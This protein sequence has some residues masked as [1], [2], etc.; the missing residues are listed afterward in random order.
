M[1]PDTGGVDHCSVDDVVGHVEQPADERHVGRLHEI[2]EGL[3]LARQPTHHEAAFGARGHDDRVL[4]DLGLQQP[5]HLCPVVLTPIG[6]ADPTAGHHA[7]TQVYAL[8]VRCIHE[9]LVER[10][11]VG[12]VGDARG[13]ELYAER[14]PPRPVCVRPLR[15]EDQLEE[16]AQDAVLV[17]RADGIEVV[18]DGGHDRVL[19]AATAHRVEPLL[20]QPHQP[21]CDVGMLHERVVHVLDGERR[22]H[23]PPVRAVGPQGGHLAMVEAAHDDESVER[24]GLGLP[25]ECR[26][27]SGSDP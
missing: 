12:N 13:A 16:P 17:E 7:S 5:E 6:P 23:P 9:D 4:G 22:A 1:N 21:R 11:R 14:G 8:D 10:L 26:L 3:T 25:V 2:A 24:V 18:A 20:E 15:G 19:V 27:H